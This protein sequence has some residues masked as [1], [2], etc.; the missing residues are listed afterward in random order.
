M[1]KYWIIRD[2]DGAFMG[3]YD[4]YADAL[5]VL[6]DLSRDDESKYILCEEGVA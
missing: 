3:W 6:E 2:D 1:V 5:M 4:N